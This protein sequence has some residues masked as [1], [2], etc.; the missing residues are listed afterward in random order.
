MAAT[1]GSNAWD[2]STQ[3]LPME[4]LPFTVTVVDDELGLEKALSI[5]KSAY[6][7]HMPEIADS[8]GEAEKYDYDPGSVILLAESKLD[9][10]P[11]G[12]M[13]IQTNQFG[14]LW[15]EESV[16]LPEAMRRFRLAEATRLG[17]V[18]SKVGRFVK[19]VLFKALYLYCL[20]TNV[21]WM[22]IAAR[23]PLDRQYQSLLFKDL[24]PEQGYIPMK[25]AGNVPHRVLG[26]D[27][28]AA[29]HMWRS[30]NHPLCGFM[31]DTHHPD[32]VIDTGSFVAEDS[33]TPIDDSIRQWRMRH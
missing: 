5:R 23:S 9:G 6:G 29:E 17:V 11:L 20:G 25:H 12:T 1:N 21:S 19:I 3:G 33:Q 13:R 32:I 31:G 14:P 8:L 24:F 2:Q 7:R 28:T 10:E 27:V 4:R 15:L 18:P 22:V 16:A 30:S 26:L